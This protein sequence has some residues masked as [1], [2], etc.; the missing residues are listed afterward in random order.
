MLEDELTVYIIPEHQQFMASFADP[1]ILQMVLKR[2]SESSEVGDNKLYQL[3]FQTGEI[4]HAHGGEHCLCSALD[5]VYFCD[6]VEARGTEL[7]NALAGLVAVAL[8]TPPSSN[9]L[10]RHVFSPQDLKDTFVPGSMVYLLVIHV[11]IDVLLSIVMC[12]ACSLQT[13]TH[14]CMY[15]HSM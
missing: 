15:C 11:Y 9:H 14:T 5:S 7:Q 1:I 12:I 3:F 6:D 13:H 2:V 10:E 4:T 8:G